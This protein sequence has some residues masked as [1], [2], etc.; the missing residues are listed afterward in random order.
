MRFSARFW[1]VWPLCLLALGA[2]AVEQGTQARL[3]GVM[4]DVQLRTAAS[5]AGKRAA[6]FCENCHGAT[7]NSPLPNV[8]N[9]AGQNPVYLLTQ[10]DKFADGR[11]QDQFMSGLVKV[12]KPE[13]RFNL[14]VFYASQGVEPTN[15]SDARLLQAGRD[16][17]QR[18]CLGCH[19]VEARGTRE[20]ARLA[21]QR[22][23]YL[24]NA[25]HDYRAAKGAR[26]DARM[27][28]VARNLSDAQIDALAAYLANLK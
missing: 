25:L 2:Q 12:L 3:E 15:V 8:P 19:G 20:I 18:A 24:A 5:L 11:R 23:G 27:T 21:G 4:Q 14:A 26:A 7:G 1:L 17:Y 16:H 13:D 28:G 10:I 22:Q 6:F 9:L